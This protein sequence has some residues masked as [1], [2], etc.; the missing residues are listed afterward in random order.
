M[1]SISLVLILGSHCLVVLSAR[2]AG[3][4]SYIRNYLC[5]LLSSRF[6]RYFFHIFLGWNRISIVSWCQY[7]RRGCSSS[8]CR[9]RFTQRNR[10]ISRKN[11]YEP[12]RRNRQQRRSIKLP[13]PRFYF[14]ITFRN[15]P[16]KWFHKHKRLYSNIQG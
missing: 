10:H 2:F 7:E 1:Y 3:V 11:P 12:Q 6:L 9:N 5:I 14:R 15:I 4:L 8:R 13:L 16:S